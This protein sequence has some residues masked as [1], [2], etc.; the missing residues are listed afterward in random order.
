MSL[1]VCSFL[2]HQLTVWSI[3]AHICCI[4]CQVSA[5][6]KEC[7]KRIDCFLINSIHHIVHWLIAA[8]NIG[9]PPIR[10]KL[11][12]L[13][14]HRLVYNWPIDNTF[15]YIYIYIYIY[16]HIH[17]YIYASVIQVMP[18]VKP[19]P[20]HI[21][22]WVQERGNSIANALELRLSCTNPSIW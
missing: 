14:K 16:I 11:A 20:E 12:V 8:L 10:Y 1:I 18:L 17:I 19:L 21:D 5:D 4:N 6:L 3:G 15:H 7:F 22:G 2:C 9:M 13:A